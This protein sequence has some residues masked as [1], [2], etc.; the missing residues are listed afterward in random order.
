MKDRI[1]GARGAAEE[2]VT[3]LLALFEGLPAD[4]AAHE[5]IEQIVALAVRLRSDLR[6]L[7]KYAD[8]AGDP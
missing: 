6:R 8:V 1:A 4:A 3:R 7:E 2:L 5:K